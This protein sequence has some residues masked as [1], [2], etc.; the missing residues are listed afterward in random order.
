MNNSIYIKSLLCNELAQIRRDI[1]M[2]GKPN[3]E[4]DIE[5]PFGAFTK[6]SDVNDYLKMVM[7]FSC[8]FYNKESFSEFH[9]TVL[10]DCE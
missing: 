2:S 7:T 6:E 8:A 1:R 10:R 5:S 4:I 9:T 3:K